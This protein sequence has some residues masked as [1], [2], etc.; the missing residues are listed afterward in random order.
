[1]YHF[2]WS[3]LTN[4]LPPTHTHTSP[5]SSPQI[6]AAAS[7]FLASKINDEPRSHQ[8]I[9]AELLK[10]WYGRPP[11]RARLQSDPAWT[12]RLFASVLDGERVL[13]HSVGF[14]FDV[15]LPHKRALQLLRLDRHE[16][17]SRVPSFEQYVIGTCNDILRNDPELVLEYSASELALAIIY[18]QVKVYRNTSVNVAALRDEPEEGADGRP[19]FARY[20]LSPERCAAITS[21]FMERLYNSLGAA[22]APAEPSDAAASGT[23]ASTLKRPREDA[24]GESRGECRS[25]LEAPEL[26]DKDRELDTTKQ[27]PLEAQKEEAEAWQPPLPGEPPPPPPERESS[28]EEGELEEGEIEG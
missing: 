7:L 23:T 19:W 3:I 25:R 13:L 21:R 18:F 5:V 16:H 26:G 20:G 15:D 9:S 11:A 22:A 6:I 1:M 12:A 14:D 17:L 2:V 4:T 24:E 8:E 10:V 28:P 27:P